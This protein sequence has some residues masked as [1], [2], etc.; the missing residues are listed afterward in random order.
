MFYSGQRIVIDEIEAVKYNRTAD[1]IV[2][3]LSHRFLNLE[4]NFDTPYLF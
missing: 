4:D 1:Y 2:N 3:K